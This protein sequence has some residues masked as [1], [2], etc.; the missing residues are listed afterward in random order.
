MLSVFRNALTIAAKGVPVTGQ[1]LACSF[2]SL[3]KPRIIN[4]AQPGFL[5]PSVQTYVPSCGFKVKGWLRKRCKDCYFI[6]REN[7]LFVLCKTHRRHKQ[8]AMRKDERNTW[9]LTHA[10]QGKVR[11]W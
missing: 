10:T 7:R 4:I 8:M 2:H 1:F 6:M 3:S 9:I 5:S 11:P